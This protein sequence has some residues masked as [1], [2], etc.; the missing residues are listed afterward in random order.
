M[1]VAAVVLNP[2]RND[3]QRRLNVRDLYRHQS[4]GNVLNGRPVV[5]PGHLSE[6]NIR[7]PG[8]FNV[9][10]PRSHRG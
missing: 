6:S 10:K 5:P 9:E 8:G 4:A 1:T 2:K 3:A 7:C